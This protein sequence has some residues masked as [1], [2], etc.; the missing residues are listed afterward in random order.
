MFRDKNSVDITK[1]IIESSVRSEKESVLTASVVGE[2]VMG[3]GNGGMSI[4]S[5]NDG[6]LLKAKGFKEWSS[7]GGPRSI[8]RYVVRFLWR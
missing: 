4:D 2:M 7:L 5:E 8:Q 1:F 6:S 3:N